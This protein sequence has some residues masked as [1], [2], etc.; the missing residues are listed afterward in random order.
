[1]MLRWVFQKR[2][3]VA[4][5]CEPELVPNPH[6]QTGGAHG[7]VRVPQV[8]TPTINGCPVQIESHEYKIDQHHAQN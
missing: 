5:A 4:P 8:E 1:M 2:P 7:F 3:P 6:N